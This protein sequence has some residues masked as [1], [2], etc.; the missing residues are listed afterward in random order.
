MEKLLCLEV[1]SVGTGPP[2]DFEFGLA[3]SQHGLQH[4]H[5]LTG[6]QQF[7]AR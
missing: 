1:E 6:S 5:C 4:G 7:A 2:P 3:I